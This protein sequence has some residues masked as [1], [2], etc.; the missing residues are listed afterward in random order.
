MGPGPGPIWGRPM[1]PGHA[2]TRPGHAILVTRPG[3][4]MTGP[5]HAITRP[6]HAITRPVP[7]KVPQKCLVYTKHAKVF[8]NP[9]P[10]IARLA[11][12]KI[13]FGRQTDISEDL[14]ATKIP[15]ALLFRCARS[16]GYAGTWCTTFFRKVWETE[17]PP[18]SCSP[19]RSFLFL[20]PG[21]AWGQ[22]GWD[23]S[24]RGP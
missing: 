1:R 21:P 22:I 5:G 18:G 12:L 23:G 16:C 8:E 17:G 3:H 20:G 9:Q 4:A 24:Q 10:G 19:K 13:V 11:G 7:R 14:P 15:R 2:M 6:G